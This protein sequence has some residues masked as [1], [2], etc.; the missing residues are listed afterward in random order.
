MGIEGGCLSLVL[1]CN[2]V[3]QY[4][5]LDRMSSFRFEL[6]RLY[7]I[8]DVYVNYDTRTKLTP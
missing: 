6:E 2:Y 3:T 1:T 8:A 7:T 5:I 4:I